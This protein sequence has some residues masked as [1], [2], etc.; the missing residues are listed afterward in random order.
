MP[1]GAIWCTQDNS[2]DLEVPGSPQSRMLMS[3]RRWLWSS[4][5]ACVV[6]PNNMHNRPFFTSSIPLCVTARR[7]THQMDGATEAV[8]FS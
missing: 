2:C 4:L 1:R 8:S 6:P 7:H 5:S 3:E